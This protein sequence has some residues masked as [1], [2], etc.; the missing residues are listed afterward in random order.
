MGY[1]IDLCGELT[2]VELSFFIRIKIVR[3]D[4]IGSV[5][6]IG[7][8]GFTLYGST[9]TFSIDDNVWWQVQQDLRD[10]KLGSILEN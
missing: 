3:H 8:R 10:G 7:I 9:Y 2:D 6:F 4:T 5:H 1:I